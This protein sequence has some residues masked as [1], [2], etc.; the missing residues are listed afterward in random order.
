MDPDSGLILAQ[1]AEGNAVALGLLKCGKIWLCPVCSAKIRHGRAEE[2]T[3]AVVTWIRQGGTA[4]LVTFTARHAAAHRLA[5]LMDAIQGTRAD[6]AKG[7]KRKPGAYQRLIT[8]GH[9]AGRP[10][11]G[12]DGIRDHVGYIGMIRATEVTVGQANGWH[13]HIHAIVLVGGR[14]TGTGADRQVIDTFEPSAGA[15]EMWQQHWSTVWTR[16]L[17]RVDPAFTP[18]DA[19]GVDFKRL[20]T[21]QDAA[22]LGQYIAKLQEGGKEISPAN[23][24]VRADLKG[25]RGGNMTP[26]QVLGRIGDLIGGVLEEDAA[27]HGSLDWCLSTWREYEPGVKGRRAIEWTRFLRQL[28]GLDGGD[29]ED[30]DMDLLFEADGASELRAGVH[31]QTRAWHK[32]AG[33]AL[34]LAAIEAV[35]GTG[36]DVAAVTAVVTA[37]GASPDSV[38]PLTPGEIAQAWEA[39]LTAL[40]DRREQAAARRRIERTDPSSH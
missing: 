11:R 39:T 32:V 18:S 33:R 36:L 26:F 34:D 23:E 20:E 15:L 7:I 29:S 25:G 16:H 3:T 13:P 10:D 5:D 8:G 9:W 24:L 1:T 17:H 12:Q 27:G 4:Y 30:D 31:V 35:E 37:A 28:L 2:I 6:A 14:T 22:D 38:R 19:H 21:A 40:A